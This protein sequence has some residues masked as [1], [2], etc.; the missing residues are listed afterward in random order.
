VRAYAAE[1]FENRR[2]EALCGLRPRGLARYRVGTA[3]ITADLAYFSNLA[4]ISEPAF[5][6]LSRSA[7][8]SCSRR[9]REYYRR[10]RGGPL[11]LVTDVLPM[12]PIA[13]VHFAPLISHHSLLICSVPHDWR[14][15]P[16]ITEAVA[17]GATTDATAQCGRRCGC[18][19]RYELDA[20]FRRSRP[21][22]CPQGDSRRSL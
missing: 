2:L 6:L 4:P 3:A 1:E 7:S 16:A 17:A 9:R 21:R 10:P 18:T 20:S 15:S 12:K 13:V 5:A 11:T 22:P 14:L 8:T 19:S